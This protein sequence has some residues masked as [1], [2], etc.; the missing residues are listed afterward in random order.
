[1]HPAFEDALLSARV[2]ER[3][4]A[5]DTT[6]FSEHEGEQ[7][8]KETARKLGTSWRFDGAGWESFPEGWHG[9]VYDN[10]SSSSIEVRVTKRGISVSGYTSGSR[11]GQQA[12]DRGLAKLTANGDYAS[13]QKLLSKLPQVAV[14]AWAAS[15]AAD[16]DRDHTIKKLQSQVNDWAEDAGKAISAMTG[17]SVSVSAYLSASHGTDPTEAVLVGSLGVDGG[18]GGDRSLAGLMPSAEPFKTFT[19]QARAVL[20]KQAVKAKGLNIE[21]KGRTSYSQSVLQVPVQITFAS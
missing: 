21:F 15:Q 5:E 14:A 1:M 11:A 4:A 10:D 20:K 8:L 7:V 13:S 18:F 3:Y 6:R 2:A 9:K 19:D 12:M 16:V 17:R